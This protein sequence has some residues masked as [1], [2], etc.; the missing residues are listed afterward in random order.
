LLYLTLTNLRL[1]HEK[2]TCRYVLLRYNYDVVENVVL[3][4]QADRQTDGRTDGRTGR[5]RNAAYYG[6]M[7][8]LYLPSLVNK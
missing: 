1:F 6:T 8:I 5:T 7:I 3:E 2:I 4:G